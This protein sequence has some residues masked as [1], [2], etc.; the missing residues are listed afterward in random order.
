MKACLGANKALNR[1]SYFSLQE[2]TSKRIG[3]SE[4]KCL[5]GGCHSGLSMGGISSAL[6]ESEAESL[7]E[8]IQLQ[9]PA[10]TS[11]KWSQ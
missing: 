10:V 11:P 1:C 8:L 7:S 2:S 6:Q 5:A 4:P 9:T 3:W